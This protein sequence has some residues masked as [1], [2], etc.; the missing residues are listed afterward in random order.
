MDLWQNFRMLERNRNLDPFALRG[1][2][3]EKAFLSVSETNWRS[4][5]PAV[6]PVG[7]QLV[8]CSIP[9]P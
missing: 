3:R 7:S 9:T 8:G 5:T 1:Q 2:T 4:L 6:N